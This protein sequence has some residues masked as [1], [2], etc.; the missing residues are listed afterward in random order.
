MLIVKNLNIKHIKA[1]MKVYPLHR[2]MFA[3]NLYPSSFSL[4]IEMKTE[5]NQID[6][7]RPLSS[8]LNSFWYLKSSIRGVPV[9]AQ[10]LTNPTNNHEVAGSVPALPQWVK[11][12]ALP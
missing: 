7:L 11:D 4:Q 9:V 8:K 3:Y 5:E 10:W 12:P 1:E 6:K 2:K